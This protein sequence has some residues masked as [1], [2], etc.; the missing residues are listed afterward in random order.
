MLGEL[1]KKARDCVHSD[2]K[3]IEIDEAFDL[4]WKLLERTNS[5]SLE[6]TPLGPEK[7]AEDMFS[8]NRML[9]LLQETWWRTV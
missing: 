3:R 9:L 4:I 1:H 8:C 5:W 7:D 6:E 2:I